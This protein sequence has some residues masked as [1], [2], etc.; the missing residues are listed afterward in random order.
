MNVRSATHVQHIQREQGLLARARRPKASTVSD[1]V[2]GP[3]APFLPGWLIW[4]AVAFQLADLVSA[5]WM[6]HERGAPAEINP[7]AR[8]AYLRGGSPGL[9]ALKGVV[10]LAIAL[11]LRD[12]RRE[13][14]RGYA[15]AVLAVAAAAGAFGCWSNLP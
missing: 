5:A 3:E 7:I 1:S 11:G 15:V 8:A 4:V 2:A 9:V 14:R 10:A 6:I 13:N 12:A